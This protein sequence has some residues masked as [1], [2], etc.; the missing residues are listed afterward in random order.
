MKI[1]QPLGLAACFA[2]FAGYLHF[3]TIM[4]MKPV[5][6]FDIYELVGYLT[7]HREY[8]KLIS[9]VLNSNTL[10]LRFTWPFGTW[11]NSWSADGLWHLEPNAIS[12]NKASE[13]VVSDNVYISF[14]S[15]LTQVM[16]MTSSYSLFHHQVLDC[17]FSQVGSSQVVT[18]YLNSSK[19]D[20]SPLL[21]WFAKT[22][23]ASSLLGASNHHHVNE[24]MPARCIQVLQKT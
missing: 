5:I 3:Q 22:K 9:R 18:P 13:I 6:T 8:N 21:L 17:V 11:A 10:V 19:M 15:L 14:T 23:Q 7:N 12:N 24:C 1:G 16:I 20:W 2:P 4:S